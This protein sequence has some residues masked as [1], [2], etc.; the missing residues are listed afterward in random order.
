MAALLFVLSNGRLLGA[1]CQGQNGMIM[2]A[3][4]FACLIFCVF[5]SSSWSQ[6]QSPKRGGA[7][8]LLRQKALVLEAQGRTTEAEQAW[9]A[10]LQ[11]DPGSAEAYAHLGL[12]A[13]RAEDYEKAIPLYR[14][15]LRLDSGVSGVRMN[16]G[17]ALFKSEHLREAIQQFSQLLKSP[18]SSQADKMR[19]QTLIGMAHYGLG[20]YSEA[21]P[22]L[23]D[24]AAGDQRNL[25]IR[26]ILAHSCLWSKQN[27]CVLDTY[28][29][30]LSI[31]PQSAEADMLAGEALD[32]MKNSQGALEQFRA[33]EK[34]NPKEPNVHF[35]TGYLLWRSKQ[36]PEAAA[37][38]QLELENNPQHAQSMLYLGDVLLQLNKPEDARRYL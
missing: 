8:T 27:Q 2:S 22:F 25:T 24:A 34:A 32:E 36:Y 18:A 30:I 9:H 20:E 28:K 3:K 19:L 5:L 4:R 7:P 15:S 37:E 11:A 38:F 21:V 12:L 10:F 6:P 17:L 23:K 16:L 26:L 31:D 1:R 33:A 35:G 13:A 29:E 14:K